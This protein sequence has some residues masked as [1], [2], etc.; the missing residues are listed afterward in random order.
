MKPVLSIYEYHIAPARYRN[1]KQKVFGEQEEHRISVDP[2][3]DEEEY[4]D[5]LIHEIMH[6]LDPDAKEDVVVER[7]VLLSVTLWKMGYR[8]VRL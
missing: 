2:R 8:R 4:L 6:Y 3:Q 7:A 5:T 1:R